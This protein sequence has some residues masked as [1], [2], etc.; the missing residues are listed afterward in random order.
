MDA[1]ADL[2]VYLSYRD[3]PKAIAW[4]THIGF[5]VL[6]RQEDGNGGVAHAEVRYGDATVMLATADAEYDTPQLKGNSVGSGT[7]LWLSTPGDVN[8]WY[9]RAVEAG[10]RGVIPPEDTG[11]GSRRA[12]VLDP[13]GHEWSVGTYRPG[14]TL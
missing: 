14:V 11:W 9:E 4:M 7:Y 5:E 6:S 12:R 8:G 10:A 3:A 2:H 13:E 1:S